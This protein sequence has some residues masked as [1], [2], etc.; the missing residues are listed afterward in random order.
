MIKRRRAGKPSWFLLL[1]GRIGLQEIRNLPG[2][3]LTEALF[4]IPRVAG[5]APQ[6]VIL[7]PRKLGRNKAVQRLLVKLFSQKP[8]K[9]SFLILRKI[10]IYP[11]TVSRTKREQPYLASPS[12]FFSLPLVTVKA[13]GRPRKHLPPC[14]VPPDSFFIWFLSK[15]PQKRRNRGCFLTAETERRHTG[16]LMELGRILKK[17]SEGSLPELMPNTSQADTLTL[18]LPVKGMTCNT[19]LLVEDLSTFPDL[20]RGGPII[21]LWMRSSGHQVSRDMSC[22]LLHILSMKNSRHMCMESQALRIADPPDQPVL[23]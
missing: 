18:P 15:G 21:L 1:T 23:V 13:P 19:A 8:A 2:I 17:S 10:I 16:S 20:L 5:V 12:R 7:P 4:P 3:P 9:V 22:L 11:G 14:W 6:G